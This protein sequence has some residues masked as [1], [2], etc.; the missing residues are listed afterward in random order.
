MY[1]VISHLSGKLN[2][3]LLR[4]IL[5]N[6]KFS[7]RILSFFHLRD[8]FLII[9]KFSHRKSQEGRFDESDE[10]HGTNLINVLW[11]LGDWFLGVAARA[12]WIDQT[13]LPTSQSTHGI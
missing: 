2:E 7:Y 8:P 6:F 3:K 11:I 12:F 1:L 4:S 5:D 9:F 13:C 10:Y